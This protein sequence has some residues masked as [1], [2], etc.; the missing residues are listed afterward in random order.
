M[1]ETTQGEERKAWESRVANGCRKEDEPA[2][3]EAQQAKYTVLS[4]RSRK[5]VFPEQRNEWSAGSAAA[6]KVRGRTASAEL[7]FL[8]DTGGLGRPPAR[9]WA[10]AGAIWV[11]RGTS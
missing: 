10:S 9:L 2:K 4:R 1:G 6:K 7:S 8:E 3:T 11:M 5:R